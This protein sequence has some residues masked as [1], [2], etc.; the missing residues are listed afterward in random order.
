MSFIFFLDN[1][2][3][4]TTQLLSLEGKFNDSSVKGLQP[5]ALNEVVRVQDPP[6][7]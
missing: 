3:V 5:Y 7:N 4:S 2:I 6:L 1:Q